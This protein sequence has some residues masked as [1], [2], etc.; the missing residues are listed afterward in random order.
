MYSSHEARPAMG[1]ASKRICEEFTPQRFIFLTLGCPKNEVTSE[2]AAA[3][4]I[5][6]GMQSVAKISDAEYIIV[7]ACAFLKIAVT[8]AKKTLEHLALSKKPNQKL[9]LFGC[10]VQRFCNSP[11][12]QSLAVDRSFTTWQDLA[13]HLLSEKVKSSSLN[14][15]LPRLKINPTYA[16]VEIAQGCSRNCAFCTLPTFKGPYQSKNPKLILDEIKALL[17]LNIPEI[18]LIAQ[19]T[20]FYGLDLNRSGLNLSALLSLICRKFPQLPRVRLM[21]AHHL[22]VTAE[23]IETL[24]KFDQ[25]CHYLDLPLQHADPKILKLMRRSYDLQGMEKLLDKLKTKIPDISL[26]S[27]FIVGFP[28]EREQEFGNLLKFLRKWEFDKVGFFAYS[29]EKNTA[30]FNY[31]DQ[32]PTEIK[33]ERLQK[34]YQ[35]QEKIAH[36]KNRK[37]IGTTLSVLTEGMKDDFHIGRSYREAPEIDGQ[38]LFT[39]KT[40]VGEMVEVKVEKVDG[41]DLI[42][43]TV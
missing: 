43:K 8:E 6:N 27:T 41:Y 17:S 12:L 30:A 16:Y 28:G 13:Y 26:R 29:R 2:H 18:I 21:Y 14:F 42:G 20:T 7:N 23:L 11:L 3:F 36:R 40:K 38:I 24:S 15:T 1:G 5:K 39:G 35:V 10:L 31:P 25:I 4:F 33:K 37:L 22:G 34:A 9:F 19:E 32:I